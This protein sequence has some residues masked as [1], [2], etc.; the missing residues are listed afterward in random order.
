MQTKVI[1][2]RLKFTMSEKFII[3]KINTLLVSF[4][5]QVKGL[6]VFVL[7]NI[8]LP[9]IWRSS[10]I[11]PA[12]NVISYFFLPS[13]GFEPLLSDNKIGNHYLGHMFVVGLFHVN[14]LLHHIKQALITM[15]LTKFPD[16][17]LSSD[18]CQ[19]PS[20]RSIRNLFLQWIFLKY[21]PMDVKPTINHDNIAYENG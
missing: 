4:N 10:Q 8:N 19:D 9:L 1:K 11:Q 6:H 2:K 3:K 5:N 7:L 18:T 21:L 20:L 13:S 17:Y 16:I 12:N 15:W 14:I